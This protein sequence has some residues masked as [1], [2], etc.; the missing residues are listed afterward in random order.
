MSTSPRKPKQS[1]DELRALLLDTGRNILRTEGLGSGAEGLTF[2]RVFDRVEA[3][4]GLRLTNASVIK[5]VWENQADYQTDVL[6]SIASDDGR[7][8]LDRTVLAL[9]EFL[10]SMD[11]STGDARWRSACEL[12][13]LAGSAN[14]DVIRESPNWNTWIG[15]WAL[16]TAGD[17]A[18]YRGAL[19]TALVDGY[20]LFTKQ[21]EEVY[22]GMAAMLGL[23]LR[24][25]FTQRQFTIAVEALAEGCGLRNRIDPSDMDGIV[26]RS[27]TAGEEQEWTLFSVGLEALLSQFFELDPDWAP[28]DNGS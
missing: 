28:P 16:A 20:E 14:V 3:D 2:K 15:V 17:P 26:R 22:T 1:R 25:R 7:E 12:C 11:L 13:R 18:V 6:I 10:G 4:T 21:L 8:E 24:E 9:V 19:E 23:R 5:R 27:G